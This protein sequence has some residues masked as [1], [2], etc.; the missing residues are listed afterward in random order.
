MDEESYV[1]TLNAFYLNQFHPYSSESALNRNAR[2]QRYEIAFLHSSRAVEKGENS[3]LRAHPNEDFPTIHEKFARQPKLSLRSS[4]SYTSHFC[5]SF[6]QVSCTCTVK[7]KMTRAE[8]PWPEML[9]LAPVVLHLGP[10]PGHQSSYWTCLLSTCLQLQSW[11][12]LRKV[13]KRRKYWEA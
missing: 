1:F 8:E 6:A 7:R 2:V 11:S 13:C 12:G 10:L 3:D 5:E 9:S 4:G